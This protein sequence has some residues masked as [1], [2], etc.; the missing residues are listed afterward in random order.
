MILMSERVPHHACAMH[1]QIF[2]YGTLKSQKAS[3]PPH[4]VLG[5]WS[6]YDLILTRLVRCTEFLNFDIDTC[7]KPL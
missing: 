7:G 6:K 3:L 4:Y 1:L 5:L 2:I